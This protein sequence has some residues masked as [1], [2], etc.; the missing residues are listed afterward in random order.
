MEVLEAAYFAVFVAWT[1][2]ILEVQK[3]SKTQLEVSNKLVPLQA[4]KFLVKQML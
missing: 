1:G 3:P 4:C 2:E